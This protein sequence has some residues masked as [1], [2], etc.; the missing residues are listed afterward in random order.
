MQSAGDIWWRL[1]DDKGSFWLNVPV[2]G[3][4]RLEESL[5]LPPSIPCRLDSGRI[6]GFVLRIF[7]GFDN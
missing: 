1:H 5:L 3:K 2:R 7:K 4:L 6:V